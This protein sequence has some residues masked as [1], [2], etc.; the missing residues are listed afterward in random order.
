MK[1]LLFITLSTTC[2]AQA[3]KDYYNTVNGTGYTLKTQL[4]KVISKHK[5]LGYGGL[6]Q[7]YKTSDVDA[8]YEKDQTVLDIYSENPKGKDPYTYK[9]GS[10]QCG[11]YG[12]EGDCYNREHI[13]PQSS[14][15]SASPMV[16]DA[17]FIPPTDG[18]VNGMRSSYPHGEVENAKWTSENGGKLG[19]SKINGYDGLVFEP[20][21][22]FKGDIARMYFYFATCYEDKV[23][24]FRY[25]MFNGSDD[26]V[27]TESFK[28]MLINWHQIDPVSASEIARNNAIYKRQ[29][30]RNP[31]I[32][33]PEFVAQIW[34]GLAIKNQPEKI[35]VS[36]KKMTSP[37]LLTKEKPVKKE[38]SI[39]TKKTNSTFKPSSSSV[40][41][42]L[43]IEG[44]GHN[45]AL[46]ITNVTNKT[47]D[48]TEYKIR[49]QVNG[50]GNWNKGYLLK[51]NLKAKETLLIVYAK[52]KL[53]CKTQKQITTGNDA[54]AFNGNDP[55]AL[56]YKSELVD[57]LGQENNSTTPFSEN[58]TLVR[59]KFPDKKN[60]LFNKNDWK[61]LPIDSCQ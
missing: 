19:S 47:I 28:K 38:A 27:F 20:I 16:S 18:K 33:H 61:I 55:I 10:D 3:P 8:F 12:K 15:N 46:A 59:T 45:K 17:H 37:T 11:I 25:E 2:L 1:R 41:F 32:D 21:D 13:I 53:N 31:Y 39:L 54:L 6:W 50:K 44:S 48:L 22:E 56:F 51:G 26:Q 52:S 23:A 29:G 24:H 43:Y 9:L 36:N 42:S 4:H 7:T 30:N 34:G 5:D 60:S 58:E 40:Y 14:F 57:I 35:K 49:K